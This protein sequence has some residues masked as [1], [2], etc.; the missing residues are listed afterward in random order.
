MAESLS[1][2]IAQLEEFGN[3]QRRFTSDVSHELRTPLTTVRMAADLIYD[4]SEDLDPALQR[5]TEL[6]VN[7]LDRFESLLSD[8]L[9]ISRHDA[10]VAELSVEAVDLRTTVNSALGNVGHLA[11]DAEVQL[12]VDMPEDG[13]IAEVD[14]RRVERILRNLIANAIDHAE[15]KPVRI[16]MATD[17][18]TVAVTVRDRARRS[19]FSAGSGARTRRGCGGP[20]EPD[21]G[22]PSASRTRG[23]IRVGWRP[24]ASRATAPAS[25]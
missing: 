8:L 16:R 4:H 19:W 1:R 22:W 14:P 23:C 24:G 9:E 13:V 5:S 12:I 7:E 25:G 20:A 6:M 10:G 18:D 15:H 17:E 2:Q 21:S 3:L 11:E